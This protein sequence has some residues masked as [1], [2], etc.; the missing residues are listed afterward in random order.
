MG[1]IILVP[2]SMKYKTQIKEYIKEHES[3]QENDLNGAPLLSDYNYELWLDYIEQA[4]HK[5]TCF[6]GWVPAS[7]YL[8]VNSS[9]EV[10][11]VINIRHELNDFLRTFGGHIGYG[12][13]PTQRRKGY[14][15]QMLT[16]A[17]HI[18]CDQGL[19]TVLVTCDKDNIASKKTIEKCGGV[20]EKEIK[21]SNGH[22]VLLFWIDTKGY[23]KS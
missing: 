7:Q 12:V 18:L 4:S 13:R 17:V 14:A 20:L 3:F 9:D 10:I 5:E 23:E 22:D 2:P 11:G 15:T 16:K 8:A 6:D 19:S 21:H 1:M